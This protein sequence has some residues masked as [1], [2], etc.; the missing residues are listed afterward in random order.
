MKT[1]VWTVY[2]LSSN[3]SPHHALCPMDINAWC[4]FQKT[5][6]ECNER[7]LYDPTLLRKCL[8]GKTQNPNESVNET[9]WT[10]IPRSTFAEIKTLKLEILVKA[11]TLKF[12]GGPP[13][14]RDPLN[15]Q[16]LVYGM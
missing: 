3:E 12:H 5:E 8:H 9:I 13:I 15:A 11:V 6:E 7:D 14:D 10:L 16:P 4:K 2:L 1:G